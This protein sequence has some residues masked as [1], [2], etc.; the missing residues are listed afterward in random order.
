M[1]QK[2]K[3]IIG[4]KYGRLT[5]ISVEGKDKYGRATYRCVCE[6][7]NECVVLGSLLTIGKVKSCGCLK[8]TGASRT[9]TYASWRSAKDRCYS[10]NHEH[11]DR[12][13]G[14]GITMCDRWRYSF[15]NFL[16]DMGERPS[17][18]YTLE[19]IDNNVGYCPDN[20]KWASRREQANN[21]KGNHLITYNEETMTVSELA[22]R[23]N[24]KVGNV[25]ASLRRGWDIDK[26]IAKNNINTL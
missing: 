21:R 9:L 11:Y 14:R 23:Y 20:C 15:D 26:I 2:R 25:F 8:G 1:N 10:K 16:K 7:G 13:G 4:E 5:P 18:D 17:K 6:C 19:R 24:I 22:R 12:Y 3:V